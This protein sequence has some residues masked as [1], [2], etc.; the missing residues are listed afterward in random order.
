VWKRYVIAPAGDEV[1]PGPCEDPIPRCWKLGE[2]SS[3]AMVAESFGL[4]SDIVAMYL[5]P[6]LWEP[7]KRSE[8]PLRTVIIS[9]IT[10]S[11]LSNL[12]H[13]KIKILRWL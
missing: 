5:I 3:S 7:H 9:G 6:F 8:E 1:D 11:E 4:R 12:L 13:I 10:L 2:I